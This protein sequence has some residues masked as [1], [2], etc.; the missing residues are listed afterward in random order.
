MAQKEGAS[1]L[2]NLEREK[3]NSFA[4][5]EENLFQRFFKIF[6]M[7]QELSIQ[8][9]LNGYQHSLPSNMNICRLNFENI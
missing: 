8:N 6:P 3:S 4:G 9:K 1:Y 2:F 5:I 7:Q